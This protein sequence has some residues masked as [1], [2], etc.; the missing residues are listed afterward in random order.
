MQYDIWFVYKHV[1]RARWDEIN[2]C[3][4]MW[5]EYGF[6]FERRKR[7]DG[8][9]KRKCEKQRDIEYRSHADGYK[10]STYNRDLYIKHVNLYRV[11]SNLNTYSDVSNNCESAVEMSAIDEQWTICWNA[12]IEYMIS[13]H[14]PSFSLVIFHFS[15][16]FMPALSFASRW[17]VFTLNVRTPNARYKYRTW[18]Y[19]NGK[20]WRMRPNE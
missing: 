17:S 13:I 9:K 19:R 14:R 15:N 5:V 12:D 1:R 16:A 20:V 7:I 8:E 18:S 10:S 2:K 6:L 4:S 11:G 3:E